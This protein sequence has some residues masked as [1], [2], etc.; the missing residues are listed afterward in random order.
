M[1]DEEK[2]KSLSY[3]EQLRVLMADARQNK[4]IWLILVIDEKMKE[5]PPTR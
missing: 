3:A 2:F 5:I 1:I 4:N